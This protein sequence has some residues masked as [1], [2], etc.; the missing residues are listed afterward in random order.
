MNHS[1][2]IEA[3]VRMEA[4]QDLHDDLV[5]ILDYYCERCEQR[6]AAGEIPTDPIRPASMVRESSEKFVH[7]REPTRKAP[8]YDPERGVFWY[9]EGLGEIHCGGRIVISSEPYREDQEREQH[10]S[11]EPERE[12]ARG[13]D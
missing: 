2:Q 4:A 9:P 5:R 8:D 6:L 3:H 7:G 13:S 10:E 12:W 11:V 1:E